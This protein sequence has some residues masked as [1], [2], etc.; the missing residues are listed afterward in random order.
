MQAGDSAVRADFESWLVAREGALQRTAYLLT[1]DPHSAQDLVQTTLAR[2]FLAW[3]RIGDLGHVDAYARKVL[4]NEHRSTW[5]RAWRRREVV[6]DDLPDRAVAAHQ[7]DGTDDAVWAFVGTLP[8]R[9]RAVIVLRYYED[10]T[11]A[12]TAELLGISVGTVKSQAHR[13]LA[14]LRATVH[15]HPA[16]TNREE[17]R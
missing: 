6:T 17:D 2:L 7:Y 13:A 9:Q 5:R 4:V 8:P 1:G 11:E 16:I 15:D 10:L 12:Q 14:A 3:D